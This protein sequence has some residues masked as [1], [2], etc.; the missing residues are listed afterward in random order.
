MEGPVKDVE[1]I[2]ISN[3]T[4]IQII[5]DHCCA[6]TILIEVAR[7]QQP[8]RISDKLC[9]LIWASC[10]GS[11]ASCGARWSGLS[12]RWPWCLLGGNAADVG[13]GLPSSWPKG[14]LITYLL[15]IMSGDQTLAPLAR[16]GRNQPQLAAL[17]SPYTVTS[18]DGTGVQL[19]SCKLNGDNYLTWSRLMRI[20]L[21]AKNKTLREPAEGEPNRAL[22][23]IANSTH[24]GSIDMRRDPGFKASTRELARDPIPTE[25]TRDPISIPPG[26]QSVDFSQLGPALAP[27]NFILSGPQHTTEPII[28]SPSHSSHRYGVPFG[29]C[30]C[31]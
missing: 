31:G 22:W 12:G 28:T 30:L 29:T 19:I 24:Q 5:S 20:S 1:R 15:Y 7:A 25:R 13:H 26:P 9:S 6:P 11:A 4:A 17:L 21:R 2:A 23:V 14:K 3:D 27:E 8:E 18:S 10:S 16:S